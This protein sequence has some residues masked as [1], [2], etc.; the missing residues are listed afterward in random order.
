VAT[1]SVL[2]VR[3]HLA[4]LKIPIRAVARMT[5]INEST[6][7]GVFVRKRMNADVAEKLLQLKRRE[8]H[9]PVITEQNRVICDCGDVRGP[10]G[11]RG[12]AKAAQRMH[13]T[14][15]R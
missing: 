10:Y 9:S 14:G 12:L 1:V 3:A 13:R 6:V 2:P 7:R 8:G 4:Q 11:T 15:E 5:G